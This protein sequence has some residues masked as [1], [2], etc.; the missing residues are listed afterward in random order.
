M[1]T[2]ESSHLPLCDICNK[3][4][5]LEASKVDKLGKAVHEG[6]YLLKVSLRRATTPPQPRPKA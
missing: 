5:K 4:I 2:S 1:T 6:C 3:P